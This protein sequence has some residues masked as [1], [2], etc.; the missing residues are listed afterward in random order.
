MYAIGKVKVDCTKCITSHVH[1]HVYWCM[2]MLCINLQWE[3]LQRDEGERD[4]GNDPSW[5]EDDGM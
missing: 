2:F 4:P 3:F 5:L 1:V